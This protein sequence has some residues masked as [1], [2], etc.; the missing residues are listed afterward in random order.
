MTDCIIIPLL[1]LVENT[2]QPFSMQQP[3]YVSCLQREYLKGDILEGITETGLNST[4]VTIQHPKLSLDN[5]TTLPTKDLSD[6]LKD[7][8]EEVN[9]SDSESIRS[10]ASNLT[11]LKNR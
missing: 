2:S 6:T 3:I 9:T 7:K 11:I 10:I 4:E 5:S 8:L 1:N